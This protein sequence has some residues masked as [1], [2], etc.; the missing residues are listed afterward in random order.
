MRSSTGMTRSLHT[1]VD[2]AIASTTT[3]AV[4]DD[5]PPMKASMA[6]ACWPCDMGTVRTKKSE[7]APC[8]SSVRPAAAIG[9]AKTH[10]SSR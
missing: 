1:I 6:S 2:S 5:R 4:A 7:S 3:I 10:I 9:S 8:G